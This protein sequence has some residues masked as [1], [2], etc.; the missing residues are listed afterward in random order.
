MQVK[1]DCYPCIL[2]QL[3][4]LAKKAAGEESAQ[5]QIV[6]DFLKIVMEADEA[7]TP[8]EFASFFHRVVN[9]KTGVHDPFQVVKDKSTALGLAM[10]PDLRKIIAD[11]NHDFEVVVRL[12]IAGNIIDYGVNPDF[13][14]S[15]AEADILSALDLP[16]DSAAVHLLKQKMDEAKRIFYMLD[17]CGEAVLDRLLIERYADKITVGVRGFP[18]LNDVTRREAALSGIDYVPIF[19]TGD[20]APGVS[21]RNSSPELLSEMR[22]A[23]LVVTKGQGNY[24]TLDT[25]DRPIFHLLRVKCGVISKVLDS[26][27]GALKILYR[28]L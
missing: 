2:S 7:T 16:F 19:D 28:N 14:L 6:R 5:R 8:P 18:I 20:M 11:R 22:K 26:P 1:I 21:L 3:S 10:L 23:D 4:E 13:D 9:Q 12:A 25:Y 17:N 15:E 24:E 27:R